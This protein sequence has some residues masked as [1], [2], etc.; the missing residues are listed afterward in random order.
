[1][2]HHIDNATREINGLNQR[3]GRMLTAV[4][5]LAAGTVDLRLMAYL[6]H[7]VRNGASVLTCAGPGGTGKTTLLGALLCFLP[8]S[9]LLQVVERSQPPSW[10]D[11]Q[12]AQRHMTWFLCHELGSGPWYSYLWGAGAKSFL[13][14]PMRNENCFCATTVHADDIDELRLNLQGPEIGIS[15]EAF[16]HLDLVLFMRAVRA[17]RAGGWLRRVTGLH[18]GIG[19]PTTSHLHLCRWDSRTD[20]F[21]WAEQCCA[22]AR[23]G[24]A[25]PAV[26]TINCLAPYVDFLRDLQQRGVV[27]VAEVRREALSFFDSE[28]L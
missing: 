21:V 14:M 11:R 18:V 10:Y 23:S 7:S 12:S 4:D 16:S 24:D 6:M 1:L 9:A 15:A 17:P 25:G 20:S 3:G 22:G 19:D 5:L 28:G 13:E 8:E 26:P 27:E 2:K